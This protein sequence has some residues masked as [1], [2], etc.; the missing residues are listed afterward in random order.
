MPPSEITN[1]SMLGILCGFYSINVIFKCNGLLCLQ[2]VEVR[3]LSLLAIELTII[4]SNVTMD[5]QVRRIFVFLLICIP[6]NAI[7]VMIK[8]HFL[9]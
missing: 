1:P 5:I 2:R 9:N 6:W 7:T 3:I 8:I 4:I